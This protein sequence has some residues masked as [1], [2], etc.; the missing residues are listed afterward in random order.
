[1]LLLKKK[2]IHGERR[3]PHTCEKEIYPPTLCIHL[4]SPPRLMF[5]RKNFC[6]YYTLSVIFTSGHRA[7][8]MNMRDRKYQIAKKLTRTVCGQGRDRTNHADERKY[9]K[10]ARARCRK[11]SAQRKP[12]RKRAKRVI[13]LFTRQRK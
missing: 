2:E 6:N 8:W 1:M 9:L 5:L 10:K 12:N 11:T 7:S 13:T 4:T 3:Q